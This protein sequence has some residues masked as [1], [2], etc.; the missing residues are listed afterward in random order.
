MKKII[1]GIFI[2]GFLSACAEKVK[3]TANSTKSKP[4]IVLLF[5]DD[6][7]RADVGYTYR[8]VDGL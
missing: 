8:N 1:A 4:N 6:W 7:G 5:V 2:V 3:D